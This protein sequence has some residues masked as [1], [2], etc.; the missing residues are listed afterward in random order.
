MV[1]QDQDTQFLAQIESHKGILYK[2]AYAY[3]RNSE[4]RGDLIQD[5]LIELWKSFR[6]F[7]GHSQFSTWM[8]RI[9]VNVAI[10][11]YRGEGRRIR[12]ALPIEDFASDLATADAA[13]DAQTDNMQTLTQ[14]LDE[15]DEVSK[16][17]VILFLDGHSYAE[18]AEIIGISAT[19]VGTR[20]NRIKTQLQ[21]GFAA[22]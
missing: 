6:H 5:I 14:L 22:G 19:N 17:L 4:D 16:A 18:I 2:V 10:S 21:R 8:Y 1:R 9:A 13:F 7:N 3:C 11:F 20:L 12:N 15:L